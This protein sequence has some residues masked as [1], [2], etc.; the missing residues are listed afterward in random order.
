MF[1]LAAKKILIVDDETS[2]CAFL[3]EALKDRFE[4][5]VCHTG[6]D[7]RALIQQNDFDLL[8]ADLVL[9]DMSG[10]DILKFAKEK[11]EWIEV[12]IITGFASLDSAAWA[13]NLG[14]SS[15]LIKPLSLDDFLHQI[16]RAAANRNFHLKSLRLMGHSEGLSPDIQTHVHDIATLYRFSRRLILSMGFPDIIQIVLHD[17]NERTSAAFCAIGI[18]FL[19]FAE[20]FAMPRSGKADE[21]AIRALIERHWDQSFE[22]L[23]K[24]NFDRGTVTLTFFEGDKGDSHGIGE[25]EPRAIPMIVKGRT[26]GSL[27]MFLPKGATLG[28][29]EAGFLY[30]YTSLISALVEHAYTDM[31]AQLLAKTDSLTGI[32]NYRLFHESLDR[33]V[34]RSNRRKFGFS[35]VIMDIDD[36][37]KVND[38]YGHLVGNEVLKDLAKIVGGMVRKQDLLARY[39]GEEF[40]MILP[41]TTLEGARILAERIRAEIAGH[42]LYFTD[43]R[44]SYTVSMGIAYYHGDCPRPKDVL[45][46]DADRALYLSK[47]K[48]KNCVSTN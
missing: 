39:G 29:T 47:S 26:I 18:N 36:F 28:D 33:E 27:A 13:I 46:A 45:I 15:Y 5:S 23:S 24:D 20:M 25:V 22:I 16:D 30:V 40:A 7:A 42:T 2:V 10:I 3:N 1:S 37:K 12:I 34:S 31:Q 4:T 43:D 38:T 8:V 48:G 21:A 35:L 19:E 9:P 14:A 44:I 6:K 32:A 11:D 41:D 17:V